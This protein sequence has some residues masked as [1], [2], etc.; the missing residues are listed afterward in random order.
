MMGPLKT[1]MARGKQTFLT[2]PITIAVTFK[3]LPLWN[4]VML[5]NIDATAGNILGTCLLE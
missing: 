2:L 4:Y 1:E 3:L 5:Y